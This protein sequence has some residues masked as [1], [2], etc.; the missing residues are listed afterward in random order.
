MI[1]TKQNKSLNLGK[2]EEI[3]MILADTTFIIDLLRNRHDVEQ[4]KEDFGN[5]NIAVSLIS[6]SEIYT[7]LYYTKS[8][9]GEESFKKKLKEIQNILLNFEILE[10][11]EEIM[12]SA[13]KMS[14]NRL[15]KGKPIDMVDLVIGAIG[16]FYNV[17]SII[18]RNIKHF[19]CWGINLVNY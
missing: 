17:K 4:I 11:N 10:L 8:K 12:I 14:A 18:T 7:G 13:G 3:G 1:K 15:L 2:I 9:L 5:K 6:I 19:E 16:K